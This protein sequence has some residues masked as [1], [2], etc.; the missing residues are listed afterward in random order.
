MSKNKETLA[1]KLDAAYAQGKLHAH[2]PP[3][4][5]M[6][7]TRYFFDLG[8]KNQKEIDE[9]QPIPVPVILVDVNGGLIQ[10]IRSNGAVR[11]VVLDSDTEGVFD[12]DR[13]ALIEGSEVYV[14]DYMKDGADAIDDVIFEIEKHFESKDDEP[15]SFETLNESKP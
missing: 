2:A 8:A 6:E 12:T 9:V 14:S 11:I 5:I 1:Q 10:N 7:L 13:L 4:K 15:K 3:T